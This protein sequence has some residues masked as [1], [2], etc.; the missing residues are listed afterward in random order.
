MIFK[1]G[2]AL[3]KI[4]EGL[5]KTREKIASNLKGVFTLGRKID[6]DLL[7]ELEESLVEAD[8]G[9][10]ASMKI[11]ESARKAYKSRQIDTTDDLLP[12]IKNDIREMLEGGGLDLRTAASPPTVILVVGVNGCGKTTS[13]AKLANLLTQEGKKVILGAADTF[14]AAAVEQLNIWS[15]RLGVEIVK[16]ETGADPAAVAFDAAEAALKR[17]ADVLIVD[18][19]G[20][21]HTKDNLMQE[22]GKISRVIKKQIPDAPHEVLLVLDGTT[23]QNALQQADTFN[24]VVDVTGIF[25][26][27]LDG[28][29]KGGVVVAI[30]ERVDIPVKFVGLGE[31]P[32]D[33][34][35][36]DAERFVEAM[37]E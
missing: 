1:R 33:I 12:Y 10:S 31:Q 21:L 35:R 16:H 25:L 24:Q 8:L 6:D 19:A 30:R 20:R 34:E 7:D 11:V 26:S 2:G 17:K 18:T 4:R 5:R 3:S 23:G 36:F 9:P 27:K 22:L 14:R 15:E 29:A 32:E 28:T 37:F 13:I